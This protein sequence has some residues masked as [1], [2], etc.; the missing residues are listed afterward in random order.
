M[1]DILAL[2]VDYQESHSKVGDRNE[3]QTMVAMMVVPKTEV[4]MNANIKDKLDNQP[5]G[6]LSATHT[7]KE[8]YACSREGDA[9][10]GV[11]ASRIAVSNVPTSRKVGNHFGRHATCSR[12][13]C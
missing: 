13:I 5:A 3:R 2:H 8:L 9:A 10:A 1:D 4:A 12:R 11:Q 7:S 6:F